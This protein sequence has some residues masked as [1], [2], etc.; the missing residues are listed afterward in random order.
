M[1]TS[2]DHSASGDSDS[3][4]LFDRQTADGYPLVVLARTGNLLIEDFLRGGFLTIV[5]C[6]AKLSLV[7]DAGM[8]QNTD[9]LYAVE[10]ELSRELDT[11]D[12]GALHLAS[13]TGDGERRI[14]FGHRSPIDF[15]SLIQK[16]DVEGYSLHVSC[17]ENRDAFTELLVP[18]ELDHQL[19]GDM[20]VISNL[21][22]NGDDG[23]AS[24]KTDFWFYG[25]RDGLAGLVRDL[26]LLGYSVDHWLNDPEGV[27]LTC[28][29]P[30]DFDTFRK[31]TPVLLG[32]AQRHG[33]T[34]DGWETFAL[35][36]EAASAEMPIK[37][38][39]QSLLSRLFGVNKN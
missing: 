28:E 20:G 26:A 18:T 25:D 13:V 9:R 15:L 24:R 29:T 16:F 11:C 31:I 12:M 10:E 4:L 6:E 34:Y 8:P 5:H 7:N 22:K 38:K 37:S 32:T 14:I 35:G 2:A 1:N 3:W 21:E 39:P 17:P 23:I 27:V 33:L 19:N 30:V 36:R